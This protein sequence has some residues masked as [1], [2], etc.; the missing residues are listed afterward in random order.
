MNHLAG[1]SFGDALCSLS[2][3]ER[4]ELARFR[5]RYDAAAP[6]AHERAAEDADVYASDPLWEIPRA[7]AH[8]SG[9]RPLDDVTLW[10][11]LAADRSHRGRADG[12]S[13]DAENSWKWL[14]NTLRW[15]RT[16]HIDVTRASPPA[17]KPQYEQ[18][19]VRRWTGLDK[20]HRPVMFERLGEFLVSS[21]KGLSVDEWIA[22]YTNDLEV[23]FEQMRAAS[24]ASE[25]PVMQYVYAADAGGVSAW[26]A[27]ALFGCIPLLTKLTKAVETHFPEVVSQIVLFNVPRI[28]LSVYNVAKG[29][30]DPVRDRA[31]TLLAPA[32]AAW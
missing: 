10:R 27:R 17:N 12:G 22:L 31:R 25:T 2:D 21:T 9:W 4:D 19:R 14:T 11:F 16:M 30:L 5:E 32:R 18:M 28:L 13:F 23:I 15:R 29:F 7:I 20:L 6:P 26:H 24:V 1:L 8:E 3:N